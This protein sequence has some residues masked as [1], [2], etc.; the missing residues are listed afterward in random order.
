MGGVFNLHIRVYLFQLKLSERFEMIHWSGLYAILCPNL[1]V[2]SFHSAEKDLLAR[3]AWTSRRRRDFC[4]IGPTDGEKE[5]RV[6]SIESDSCF[7]KCVYGGQ[8]RA[9]LPPLP[10]GPQIDRQGNRISGERNPPGRKD[11]TLLSGTE[12]D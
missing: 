4:T 8:T 6:S 5:R 1:H 9:P 7:L 3:S 10:P 2:F 11:D 12:T